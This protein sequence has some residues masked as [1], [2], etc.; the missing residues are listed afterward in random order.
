VTG[1]HRGGRDEG[2]HQLIPERDIATLRNGRVF[3]HDLDQ[4]AVTMQKIKL[5]NSDLEVSALCLGTDSIGSK[6]DRNTS[7][8]LLDFFRERGG[9]FIDTANFYAA[10]IPGFCGGES[11]S[12]IGQWMKERSARHELIIATKLGFDYPGCPGGLSSA[13]IERECEKSLRRLG[14][15]VID[16]LYAHRDDA[17]TPLEETMRA[18]D[19]LVRAGKVRVIGASNLRVWRI[20]EANTISRQQGA[21]G[22]AIV[23]QR[24]TYLLPRHGSDFGPQVAVNDDLKEY[25]RSKGLTLVAYSVLLQ[26]AYTR[27]ERAVPAQYAGPDSDQRLVVL[28][29]VA[30]EIGVDPNQVVVAWLRQSNPPVLPIIAGSKIEQLRQNVGALGLTLSDAHMQR[31]NQAGNPDIKQAWIH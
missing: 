12:T 29:A 6:I 24:H 28:R 27:P 4:K 31:L 20:A 18:F 5:G 13:E 22:Y 2:S 26:G 1:K 17:T 30:A 23:Q 19:R 7:F 15:D 16:I 14:T 11:E 3:R 25:C 21:P 9:T 10:W 8:Q